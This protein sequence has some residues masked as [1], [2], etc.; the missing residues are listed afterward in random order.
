M[1]CADDCF[2]SRL[3]GVI[4]LAGCPLLSPRRAVCAGCINIDAT[5]TYL[6]YFRVVDG[7]AWESDLAWINSLISKK[8]LPP[9]WQLTRAPI[10]VVVTHLGL[11]KWK[12][13]YLRLRWWNCY[14]SGK[15][16]FEARALV[17]TRDR[18]K[19]LRCL[20]WRQANAEH[21]V[22]RGYSTPLCAMH[23]R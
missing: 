1:K 19:K 23:A 13:S 8:Y 9:I 6:G 2:A 11:F 12:E 21:Y 14:S 16:L 22:C 3:V 4:R 5:Y 10:F 17:A 18:G 15:Y 7:R 20:S